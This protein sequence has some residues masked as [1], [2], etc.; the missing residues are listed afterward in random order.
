MEALMRVS[1]VMT[2]DVET[3]SSEMSLNEAARKMRF[4]D[5]G[6]LPVVENNALIG[7]V[8]DRD[9]A[10]RGLG[11]GRVAEIATVRDIMTPVVVWCYENDVLTEAVEVMENYHVRRLL[12]LDQAKRLVGVLSLDDLAAHMSSDRLLGTVLRNVAARN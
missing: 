5:I 8:T 4:W 10:L 9:I 12:V 1:E 7:V 11:E 2:P 3:V 6:L